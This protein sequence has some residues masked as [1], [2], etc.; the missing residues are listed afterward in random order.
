MAT[1]TAK[2]LRKAMFPAPRG[3]ATQY[4]ELPVYSLGD[5]ETVAQARAA[6]RELE[7]GQFRNAAFLA[8]MM[9]RDDRVKGVTDTRLNGLLGLPH[10]FEPAED[11]QTAIEVAEEAEARWP[12][13]APRPELRR[14]LRWG[15][16]LGIGVGRNIWAT[17]DGEWIPRLRTYHPA[18]VYWNWTTDRY[19][20]VL[21]DEGDVELPEESNGDWVIFAPYG[22]YRGWMDALVRCLVHPWL[23]RTWARRDWA[24]YS[25]VHGSPTKVAVVPATASTEA[26]NR[27][28][29]L[30]SNL[31]GEPLVELQQGKDGGW[32]FKLV[33]AQSRTWEGFKDLIAHCDTCI[34]VATLGQ[35]L[36][37]EVKEG[38]RAAA[39]VHD[40]VR[41]DV[42]QADAHALQET[43]NAG[44]LEPW[45]AYRARGDLQP[46]GDDLAPA[47]CIETEPPEDAAKTA[48]ALQKLGGFLSAAKTAGAP[49]D[50]RALLERMSVPLLSPEDEAR[51]KEEAAARAAAAQV[52]LQ[53]AGLPGQD[54][55]QPGVDPT[56]LSARPDSLPAGARRGQAYVDELAGRAVHTA[57]ALMTGELGT[58]LALVQASSSPEDLRQR[59]AQTFA[60]MSPA[61]LARLAEKAHVM[62]ELNGQASV[63]E[64]L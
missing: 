47:L 6:L 3:G 29:K 8:E 28:R 18:N 64:D 36:T 37:T 1:K 9:G 15:L 61:D 14:L 13:M 20:I 33:E 4:R 56:K 31:G 49:V 24:R 60:G 45:A 43:V 17:K 62:A 44:L 32:D 55:P 63:L 41:Q 34:A 54:D 42:Q 57:R 12:K 46:E 51:L 11:S 16:M 35:N 26:K 59:L 50:V 52:A 40:Q 5:V 19:H 27:F 21:P 22:Y 38:S 7:R 23:V 48:D 10:E 58:V 25:E 30:L 53:Q 2:K 39:Q